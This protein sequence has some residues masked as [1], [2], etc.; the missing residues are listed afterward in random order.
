METVV[1]CYETLS[2]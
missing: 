2:R 1:K